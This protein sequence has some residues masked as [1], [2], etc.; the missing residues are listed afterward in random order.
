MA[1]VLYKLEKT[2]IAFEHHR[3][4]NSKLCQPI[5][6]YPKFYAISHF[7]QYI[8]NYSSTV[9]YSTAYS[10][11]AH[12][13]FLK[14]FYNRTNKKEYDLQIR[15]YNIRH[16][17]ITAMK[18]VIS[19]EKAREK[20]SLLE[21]IADTI[22]LAEMAQTS[23]PVDLVEKYIWPM[24]NANLDATKELRLTGIK[25]YWRWTW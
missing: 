14:V 3:P 19:E 22:A 17:Y 11:T 25:K 24:S 23:S 18:D 13:Y 20:K 8:R 4:I 2:K 12:K 15:Q 6:N 7:V 21:G 5:F 1:H 16:T 10:E 9:N